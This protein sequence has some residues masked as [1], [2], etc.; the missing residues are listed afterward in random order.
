MD[1]FYKLYKDLLLI[2]GLKRKYGAIVLYS[3]MLDL[4]QLSKKNGE[5]YKDENGYFVIYDSKK[6]QEELDMPEATFF[7]N[8]R[9]LKEVGLIDYNEQTQKRAGVSTPI[10]VKEI[11]N[12]IQETEETETPDNPF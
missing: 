3:A 5:R 10:Y 8:K 2:N 11:F 7:R 9:L 6:A 12:A 4:L 1:K